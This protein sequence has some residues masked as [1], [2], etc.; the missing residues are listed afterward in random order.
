MHMSVLIVVH[1][2]ISGINNLI[3]N[4]PHAKVKCFSQNAEKTGKK[5][6]TYVHHHTNMIK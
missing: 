3:Y 6:N 4:T 1:P 2:F 5:N